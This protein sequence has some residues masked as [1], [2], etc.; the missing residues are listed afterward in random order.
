MLSEPACWI[1]KCKHYIGVKQGKDDEANERNVCK[2]FPDGIPDEIAYGDN[3][4][5]I[6]LPEQKG[7]FVYEK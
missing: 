7:D 6:P 2:A 4:H 5:A 1:R 3:F